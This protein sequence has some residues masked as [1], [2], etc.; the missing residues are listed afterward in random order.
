[1]GYINYEFIYTKHQM[2]GVIEDELIN[3]I[4]R[5]IGFSPQH[6][7]ALRIT[8]ARIIYAMRVELQLT[9]FEIDFIFYACKA[10]LFRLRRNSNFF[11]EFINIHS[12]I[13]TAVLLA[14]KFAH[15][16]FGIRI[17]D[18]ER[19]TNVYV[20]TLEGPMLKALDWKLY[21]D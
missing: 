20:R 8:I 2:D 19:L 17:R 11:A 21:I 6:E 5:H 15:C 14:I 13:S 9:E 10:Y 1:M 3:F 4:G 12:I 16:D 7:N 18:W